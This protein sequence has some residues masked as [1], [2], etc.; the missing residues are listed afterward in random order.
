MRLGDMT[1]SITTAVVSQDLIR[2]R[3]VVFEGHVPAILFAPT[4]S[5]SVSSVNDERQGS[6]LLLF[7]LPSL[8][9]L[10]ILAIGVWYLRL[11][12]HHRRERQRYH[13]YLRR[14]EEAE[15]ADNNDD[16]DDDNSVVVVVELVGIQLDFDFDLQV[17]GG[18]YTWEKEDLQRYFARIVQT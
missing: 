6:L 8:L 9:L 7:Q 15:A 18:Y 12:I 1:T 14:Q 13:K 3:L 4:S 10:L 5:F 2:S 17:F 11:T 16:I